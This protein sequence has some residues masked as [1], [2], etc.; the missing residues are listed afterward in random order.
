MPVLTPGRVGQGIEFDGADDYVDVG[1]SDFGASSELTIA[2]WIKPSAGGSGYELVLARDVYVHSFRLQLS[3]SSGQMQT[4][5]RTA[6]G[7]QYLNSVSSLVTGEW[8][9]FAITYRDGERVLYVDGVED[10]SDAPTGALTAYVDT[11]T[12]GGDG[13]FPGFRGALDEVRIYDR[14]LDSAEVW[15]L[16]QP[17]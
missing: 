3:R 10:A 16:A 9:H 7:A 17:D 12:L 5:I 6:S 2:F 11:T 15:A 4:G 14:A 13:V 1:T 8:R